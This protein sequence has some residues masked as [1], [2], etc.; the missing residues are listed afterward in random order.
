MP[1]TSFPSIV[2]A[3]ETFSAEVFANAMQ[4]L[5]EFI[6]T[7]YQHLPWVLALLRPFAKHTKLRDSILTRDVV[8]AFLQLVDDVTSIQGPREHF[9]DVM[10]ALLSLVE[11]RMLA[12]HHTFLRVLTIL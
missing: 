12:N 10:D 7:D 9:A 3:E 1:L 6:R 11:L 2:D 5:L 4:S 8:K